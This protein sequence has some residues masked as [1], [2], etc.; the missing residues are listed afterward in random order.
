LVENLA[1]F[2]EAADLV[3]GEDQVAVHFDVEDAAAAFNQ[4]AVDVDG[5]FDRV[6]QT[7]GFGLVISH[8]AV[9]DADMHGVAPSVDCCE[10]SS[11]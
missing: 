9:L 11:A 4:F 5:F 3:F 6:R 8:P 7:G 2:G 10:Q 1:V